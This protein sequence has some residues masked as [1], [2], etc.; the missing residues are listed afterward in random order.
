MKKLGLA[1]DDLVKYLANLDFKS[2][3]LPRHYNFQTWPSGQYIL[4]KLDA[5]SSILFQL[6]DDQKG[7]EDL[8]AFA[9]DVADGWTDEVSEWLEGEA[10][11]LGEAG[12]MIDGKILAKKKT[13]TASKSATLPE[14]EGGHQYGEEEGTSDCGFDCGAWMGPTRSGGPDPF[15][16][17]PRNPL[18]K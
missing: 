3:T 4:E 9:A 18:N 16:K 13:R 11:A 15:G 17:C 14:R 7:R 8:L 1:V 10:K 5:N 2:V 6:K 12:G